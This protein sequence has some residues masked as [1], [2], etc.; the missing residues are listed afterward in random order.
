[1]FYVIYLATLKSE[2]ND[3]RNTESKSSTFVCTKIDVLL[4]MLPVTFDMNDDHRRD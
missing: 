1:M 3:H 2:L 4:R